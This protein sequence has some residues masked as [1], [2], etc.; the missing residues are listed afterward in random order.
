MKVNNLITL[1]EKVI[2]QVWIKF[3]QIMCYDFYNILYRK[4]EKEKRVKSTHA[5]EF[6]LLSA[7][8][9]KIMITVYKA[10]G[11]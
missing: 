5:N 10:N 6:F 8:T 1:N 3:I 2:A 11:S 7:L 9:N 4:R